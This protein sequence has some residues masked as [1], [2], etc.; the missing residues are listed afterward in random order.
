MKVDYTVVC[1][2]DFLVVPGQ[3]A[4][5]PGASLDPYMTA[6]V[7]N[8]M[9]HSSAAME[10]WSASLASSSCDLKVNGNCG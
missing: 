7:H 10:T 6:D 2:E 5:F 8:G 9:R 4:G 1:F 3:T